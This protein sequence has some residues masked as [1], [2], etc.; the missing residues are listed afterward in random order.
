[1]TLHPN[2]CTGRL[3]AGHG[4]LVRPNLWD[5]LAGMFIR[6]MNRIHAKGREQLEKL[7][8]QHRETTE[9]LVTAFAEVLG[10]LDTDPPDA[11]AGRL[12][13]QVIAPRGGPGRLLADCEAVSAYHG[14][15]YLPL[16]WR[17]YR[18]QRS[19]LFRLVRAL[20]FA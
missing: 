17:S 14:D 1:M 19:V 3:A 18:G 6:L 8:A 15:N 20:Q 9:A 5:D 16:L 2:Q 13:K 10:V 12:V 11:E 4:V 7:R